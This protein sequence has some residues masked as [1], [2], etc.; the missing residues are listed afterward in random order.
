MAQCRS[1]VALG[2]QLLR[3]MK[4]MS[5]RAD[6]VS[7]ALMFPAAFHGFCSVIAD[8]AVPIDSLG[9]Q[10]STAIAPCELRSRTWQWCSGAG[11]AVQAE[12][13]RHATRRLFG[14]QGRPPVT[15]AAAS[16]R[17]PPAAQ[18]QRR[19]A[20]GAQLRRQQSQR[21]TSAGPHN[22]VGG[23]LPGVPENN[24]LLWRPVA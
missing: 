24:A 12:A 7:L 3:T 4:K 9:S 23:W 20:A 17:P 1:L 6:Q 18:Q 11:P 5:W 14:T 16:A 15:A 21:I 2:S 19:Q 13:Q 22:Q 8:L 10:R